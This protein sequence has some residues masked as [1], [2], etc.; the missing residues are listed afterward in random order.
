MEKTNKINNNIGVFSVISGI[1]ADNAIIEPT[2]IPLAYG[3]I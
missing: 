1:D 3:A 2:K